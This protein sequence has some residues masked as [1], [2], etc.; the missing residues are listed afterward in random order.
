[1]HK[2]LTLPSQLKLHG[3]SQQSPGRPSLWLCLQQASSSL[4]H[5]RE[6]IH[7]PW[8]SCMYTSRP[9]LQQHFP[10]IGHSPRL[11]CILTRLPSQL[12]LMLSDKAHLVDHVSDTGLTC[13]LR[14]LWWVCHPLRQLALAQ[15]AQQP[16]WQGP[17]PPA[18]HH[19]CRETAADAARPHSPGVQRTSKI[20]GPVH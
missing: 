8:A 15:P 9:E 12:G 20:G 7:S 14:K 13:A 10:G 5:Q 2:T 16:S 6:R 18:M 11:I 1:M 19:K 17:A 4:Q 3:T